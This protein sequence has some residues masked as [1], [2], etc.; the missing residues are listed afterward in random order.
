MPYFISNIN[1]NR[2]DTGPNHDSTEQVTPHISNNLCTIII[3]TAPHHVFRPVHVLI[4]SNFSQNF[5]I[6]NTTTFLEKI[7]MS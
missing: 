4:A 2:S 1:F 7:P 3:C 6:C 5:K